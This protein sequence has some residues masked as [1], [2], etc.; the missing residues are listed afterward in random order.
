MDVVLGVVLGWV[1]AASV[2]AALRLRRVS[3]RVVTP[4]EETMRI[5]VHA[6]TATLPHLR[7]GLTPAAGGRSIKHLQ[8]LVQAPAVALADVTGI[9]ASTGAPDGLLSAGAPLPAWCPRAERDKLE[10]ELHLDQLAGDQPFGS[11]VAAPLMVSDGGRV[12]SLLAFYRPG[13][14][15]SPEDTRVVSETASLVA[16]QLELAQ[17]ETQR[18]RVAR[19]ELRALRAQISPHFIYNALAAVARFTRTRPDEARE[20]LIEFAEFTRYAFRGERAYVTLADELNNVERYLRLEQAR[21]GERLQVRVN[22]VPEIL[23]VVVPIL[24]LQPLVENA[25]RHGIEAT[26]RG[27]TVEIEGCDLDAD[28]EIIVR[29]DGPG[30]DVDRVRRLLEGESDGVGLP[31]VHNRLRTTFG[32]EYGL[33][34]EERD[35]GGTAVRMSV[36]KFRAG[37]RAS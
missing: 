11:V 23:M 12:G 17:L 9:V 28:V 27:G 15:P 14:D 19:A 6:A 31:N 18:E 35:G 13:E 8:S 20:L 7:H 32:P 24:S 3:H 21:F 25:I 36:P 16:A 33:S 22:V 37:V 34:V 29:D 1:T 30:I 4:E 10:V 26:S 5:A 2:V